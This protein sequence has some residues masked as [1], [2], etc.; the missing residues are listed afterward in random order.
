MKSF[1]INSPQIELD[2]FDCRFCYENKT[3]RFHRLSSIGNT[4]LIHFES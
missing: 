3:R 2:F 4:K 1:L